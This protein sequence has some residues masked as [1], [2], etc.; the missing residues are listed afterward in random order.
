MHDGTAVPSWRLKLQEHE[1]LE[2]DL[3]QNTECS[4]ATDANGVRKVHS[5]STPHRSSTGS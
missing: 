1:V 3:L 5:R 4:A 2:Q